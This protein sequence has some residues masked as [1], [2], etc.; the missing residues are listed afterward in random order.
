MHIYFLESKSLYNNL[1]FPWVLPSEVDLEDL[2][3]FKIDLLFLKKKNSISNKY[4]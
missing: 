4:S 3:K 1:L 2:K